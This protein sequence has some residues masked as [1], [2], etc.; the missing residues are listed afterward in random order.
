MSEGDK[1]EEMCG[2][3]DVIAD[4]LFAGRLSDIDPTKSVEEIEKYM[5]NTQHLI[6]HGLFLAG[7]QYER[8][9]ADKPL[10]D[11][12]PGSFDDVS[13]DDILKGLGDNG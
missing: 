11:S 8:D 2:L 10:P 4:L 3:V 13:I 6:L 7:V 9:M 12:S 1:H 5:S